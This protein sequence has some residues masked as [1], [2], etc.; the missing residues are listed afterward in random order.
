MKLLIH[1]QNL[2]CC[3]VEMCCD[4]P[5][6]GMNLKWFIWSKR[7][8]LQW[9]IS[10]LNINLK[11]YIWG[12]REWASRSCR[13]AAEASMGAILSYKLCDSGCGLDSLWPSH[14]IWHH[15]TWSTLVQVVDRCLTALKQ[16]QN[17]FLTTHQCDLV[18]FTWGQFHRIY[19]W[20]YFENY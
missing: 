17:Q 2:N 18:A 20:Y 12:L 9:I 4:W 6:I 5:G 11:Q 1:F 10:E 19:P 13:L 3:I 7:V 14:P 16:Y 8:E 15:I